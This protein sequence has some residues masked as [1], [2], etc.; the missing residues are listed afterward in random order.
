LKIRQ[1]LIKRAGEFHIKLEDVSITDL[2]FG[3]DF[4]D[5]VEQKVIGILY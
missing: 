5:A 4:T 3:K 1:E 2:T